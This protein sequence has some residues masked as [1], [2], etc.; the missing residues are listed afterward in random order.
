MARWLRFSFPGSSPRVRGK[1]SLDRR[2]R[3]SRG[4]I[5]AR[6]GKTVG[7]SRIGAHR[8]AHPRV[9]GENWDCVRPIARPKGSSPRVRGKRPDPLAHA[10]DEGLIPARAGKTSCC[11]I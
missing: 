8:Q 11:L 10:V 4:L 2:I 6:A 1:H 9:C 5:P 3:R 7:G